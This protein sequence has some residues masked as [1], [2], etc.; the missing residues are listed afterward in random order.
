[1]NALGAKIYSAQINSDKANIDISNQAKGVYFYLLTH[2]TGVLK[3][4]KIILE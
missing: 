4:G 3:T 1:M 2:E